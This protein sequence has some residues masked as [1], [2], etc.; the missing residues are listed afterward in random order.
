MEFN[1][2]DSSLSRKRRH[3]R[4]SKKKYAWGGNMPAR[5]ENSK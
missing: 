2:T 1:G 4:S 3:R 5:R